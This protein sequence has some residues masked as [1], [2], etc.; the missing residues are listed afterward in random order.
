M[1][2]MKIAVPTMAPGGLMGERS[3]HFGHCDL[4]TLI[5]IMDGNITG[6]ETVGNASH[7]KGGCT[8]P[9]QLLW[10]NGVDTIVVSGMGGRPLQKFA[11]AGIRVLFAPKSAGNNVQSLVNGVM[12]DAYTPM[13]AH[14]ACKG[15]GNC[16]QK[17]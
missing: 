13:L 4:F 5:D 14:Q 7:E 11:E 15:H 10:E 9:V 12:Q 17:G 2:K 1:N 6:I 8:R 3:E 16:H